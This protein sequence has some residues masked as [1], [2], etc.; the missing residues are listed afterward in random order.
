MP[1]LVTPLRK[2]NSTQILPVL[3]KYRALVE[4]GRINALAILAVEPNG[5]KHTHL[6]H[7]PDA[8]TD[9]L[10]AGLLLLTLQMAQHVLND[11]TVDDDVPS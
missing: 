7:S 10:L 8:K 11:A 4:T 5:M 6:V 9:S 1:A 3:E 2:G